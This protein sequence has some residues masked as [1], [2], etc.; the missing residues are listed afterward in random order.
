MADFT[1]K[2]NLKASMHFSSKSQYKNLSRHGNG[3]IKHFK[4][5]MQ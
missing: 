1:N 3:A 4:A 2:H 5:L